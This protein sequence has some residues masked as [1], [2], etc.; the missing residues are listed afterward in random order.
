MTTA[1]TARGE[2]IHVGYLSCK[3][4]FDPDQS[5]S[6][7]EKEAGATGFILLAVTKAGR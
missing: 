7:G 1:K 4:E 5:V 6:F 2:D 3:V